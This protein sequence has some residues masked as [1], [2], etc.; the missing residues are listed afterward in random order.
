MNES[1]KAPEPGLISGILLGALNAAGLNPLG[2]GSWLFLPRTKEGATT[3]GATYRTLG[4]G[5][6]DQTPRQGVDLSTDGTFLYAL[7]NLALSMDPGARS[8]LILHYVLK[9][10]GQADPSSTD[11]T[12]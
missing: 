9:Q 6:A 1:G 2:D 8:F 10:G 4:I 3:L 7:D 11:K 5:E 12:V